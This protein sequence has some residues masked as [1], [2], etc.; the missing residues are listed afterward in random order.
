MVVDFEHHYIPVELARRLGINTE[1]KVADR[2]GDATVRSQ[3]FDLYAQIRDIDRGIVSL[4][5]SYRKIREVQH[6]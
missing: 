3:S 4:Y 5:S 6:A 1:G 2:Q